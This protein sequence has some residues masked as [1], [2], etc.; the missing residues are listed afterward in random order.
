MSPADVSSS[1]CLSICLTPQFCLPLT[2]TATSERA[3][4]SIV[5]A[6]LT[7]ALV[8]LALVAGFLLSGR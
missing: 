5:A 1:T 3:Q 8:L 2:V 4:A 6:A 7:L